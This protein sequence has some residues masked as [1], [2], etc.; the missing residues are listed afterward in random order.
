MVLRRE[1]NPSAMSR[2][3]FLATASVAT[4]GV[5][6]GVG[7]TG[8]VSHPVTGKRTLMLMS[9]QQEIAEDRMASPHQFSSD[10]GAVQDADLNAYVNA[11]GS[12]MGELSHRP[13][14]PTRY[15]R[16]HEWRKSPPAP[17]T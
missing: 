2:R 5:G 17:T 9:E 7:L 13:Q 3:S 12:R 1:Q 14:M 8:C 11:V 16:D 4:V 6:A 10:Y 15:S